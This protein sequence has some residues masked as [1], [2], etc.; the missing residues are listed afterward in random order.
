MLAHHIQS[1]PDSKYC[2]R[3]FLETNGA[4]LHARHMGQI[5]VVGHVRNI[6]AVAAAR[7]V[8]HILMLPGA[9]PGDQLRKLMKACEADGI[10]LK[11]IPGSRTCSAAAG[12][13][14][15]ATS[16][17]ATCSAASR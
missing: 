11:L 2:V 4:S 15:S 7:G 10:Q 13:C 5:P 3:G 8:D 1:H 14:P 9:L 16:R 17:S 12:K 6:E